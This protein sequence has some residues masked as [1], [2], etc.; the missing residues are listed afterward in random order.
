M[1]LQMWNGDCL[2]LE[3]GGVIIDAYLRADCFLE[4][5]YWGNPVLKVNRAFC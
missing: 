5:I 1:S 4:K 2:C 3:G